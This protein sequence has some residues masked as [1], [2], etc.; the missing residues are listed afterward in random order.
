MVT[1]GIAYQRMLLQFVFQLAD[2][3]I[4]YVLADRGE[5][6][7]VQETKHFPFADET[8]VDAVIDNQFHTGASLSDRLAIQYGHRYHQIDGNQYEE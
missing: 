8:I 2:I 5:L 6:F 4:A 1:F 7:A 3:D